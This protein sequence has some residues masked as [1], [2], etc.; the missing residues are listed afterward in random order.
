MAA[1]FEIPLI[2]L[3]SSTPADLLHAMSTCGFI[4]LSL[5][6]TPL[7]M[8]DVRHTFALSKKLFDELPLSARASC[9]QD[10]DYNGHVPLGKSKLAAEHGQKLADHKEGFGFGRFDPPRTRSGQPL[11]TGFEV[12]REDLE[13]FKDKCYQTMLLL[14]DALSTAF[15]LPSNFFRSCHTNPGASG[16]SLLNYP[17]PPAGLA[18][19]SEADIRAG[20]HKD[21]GSVTLL[22]QEEGGQSGLE[23]FKPSST[24]KQDGVALMSQVDLEAGTWHPAPIIPNT[25]LINLGLMMEAWTAGKCI[26]TLHRVVFPKSLVAQ[27]ITRPRK[28]IAYFGTP[29]PATILRPVRAGGLVEEKEGAPSVKE[30]FDERMRLGYPEPKPVSAAA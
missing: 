27:P 3:Q 25:V 15:D 6:G 30:F 10:A 28:S 29:D 14:L 17:L 18:S 11:P 22:F 7:T 24:V 8:D 12:H 13:S 16:L 23:V 1:P 5:N 4:H 20:A 2:D 21:W 26:A 19:L 9:P